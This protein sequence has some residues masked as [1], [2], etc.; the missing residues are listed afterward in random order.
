MQ[1]LYNSLTNGTTEY[2]DNGEIITT[3]PTATMLRAARAIKQ[4]IEVN[5]TNTSTIM[6]LQAR[7]ADLLSDLERANDEIK[8]LRDTISKFSSV[9]EPVLPPST[10]NTDGEGI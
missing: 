4:A 7:E 10:E 6:S 1:T 3:P 8:K 2:R 9:G 5:T